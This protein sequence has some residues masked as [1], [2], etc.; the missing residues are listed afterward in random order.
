METHYGANHPEYKR[1]RRPRWTKLK[2]SNYRAR[3]RHCTAGRNRISGALDRE[4]MLQK[5]VQETKAEFDG[6]TRARLNTRR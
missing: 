6:L 4:Q 5:A 2:A 1:A 3:R